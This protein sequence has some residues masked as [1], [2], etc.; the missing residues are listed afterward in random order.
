M[1]KRVKKQQK[2]PK[3]NKKSSSKKASASKSKGGK[4]A[5]AEEKQWKAKLKKLTP[6]QYKNLVE[7]YYALKDE[8]SEIESESSNCDEK[9]AKK[10]E[11]LSK[12]KAEVARLK[13]ATKVSSASGNSESNRGVL[14][15]IQIGSYEQVDLSA[16]AGQ[17]NFGVEKSG[18]SQ[19]F[20]IGR[21]RNFRKA[22]NL[23]KYLQKMGVKDAWVVAYK[24]G[25]RVNIKEVLKASAR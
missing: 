8:V 1:E 6:K 4:S 19:K 11:L 24:N 9:I 12:Y 15:R 10:E 17:E 5:K 25:Q 7:D 21:F 23:K 3:K 20:T 13:Q 16:Y 14:F 18:S 2:T 22:D